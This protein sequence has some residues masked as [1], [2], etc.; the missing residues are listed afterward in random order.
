MIN[1]NI[2]EKNKSI[3]NNTK[4]HEKNNSYISRNFIVGANSCFNNKKNFNSK[5][6]KKIKRFNS[7]VSIESELLK[8]TNEKFLEKKNKKLTEKENEIIFNTTNNSKYLLY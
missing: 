5:S 3:L 1:K 2:I 4:L 7:F 8:F 6:L